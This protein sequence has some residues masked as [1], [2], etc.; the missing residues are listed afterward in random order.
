MPLITDAELSALQEI[1]EEGMVD[2]CA[3]LT[4][5]PVAA[6]LEGDS[7]QTF[8]ES[9]VTVKCW[10]WELPVSPQG[11]TIGGI[12]AIETAYRLYLPVGTPVD[13]GDRILI[14]GHEYTVLASTDEQTYQPV[15]RLSLRRAE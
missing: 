13:N 5:T 10:L 2:T 6:G 8:E 14:K 3:I 12:E 11:G 4:R 9:S 7:E 1:A 15:L